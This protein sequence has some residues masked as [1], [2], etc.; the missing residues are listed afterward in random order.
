MDEIYEVDA[1]EAKAT[2][3]KL[4]TEEGIFAGI[5]SGGAAAVA[6]RLA[7]KLDSGLIVSIACDGGS[8]YLSSDLYPL[9][10]ELEG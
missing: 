4:A 2:A 7:E 6:L 3:R 1:E 9:D 8:R 10:V 5:S